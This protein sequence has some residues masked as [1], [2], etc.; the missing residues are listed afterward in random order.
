[1]FCGLRQGENYIR[2]R[3]KVAKRYVIRQ[4]L[5]AALHKKSV[6][7]LKTGRKLHSQKQESSKMICN[8][9]AAKRRFAQKKCS[10]AYGKVEIT[11]ANTGK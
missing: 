11:Y 7:R 2:K 10:A 6:L 9:P 8:L 5:S 4:L 1:M 3:K